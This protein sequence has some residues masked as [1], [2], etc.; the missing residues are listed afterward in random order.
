MPR[1]NL[2]WNGKAVSDKVKRAQV[3]GINRTLAEC[4]VHAKQNHDWKNDTA[5]L[6]GGISIVEYGRALSEGGARGVWGVADVI[7]ARIHELGGTI[8]PVRAKKLAIPQDDGSVRL[9]DSV[10]IPARPY[11]R[12]AADAVYPDLP[13]NIRRAY[14]QSA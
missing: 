13:A 1:E 12:P 3:A 6:E 11:L 9:V 2:T 7:Y 8:R 5:V 10:T 4:T 14:E